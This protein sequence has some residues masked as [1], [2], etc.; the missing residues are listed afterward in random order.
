MKDRILEIN[1]NKYIYVL[2]NENISNRNY[3][4]GALCDLDK[5]DINVSNL[6]VKEVLDDGNSIR[7]KSIDDELEAYNVAGTLINKFRNV[8]IL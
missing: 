6:L 3:I 1:N 8:N 4:L 5:K 7:I 2:E